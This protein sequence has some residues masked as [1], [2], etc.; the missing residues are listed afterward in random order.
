[1]VAQFCMDGTAICVVAVHAQLDSK[2]PA[3]EQFI[4]GLVSGICDGTTTCQHVALFGLVQRPR[5]LLQLWQQID[6]PGVYA[7]L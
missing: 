5:A 1:M 2:H 3:L 4:S 7:V 6:Q